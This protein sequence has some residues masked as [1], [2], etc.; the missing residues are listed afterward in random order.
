MADS[1]SRYIH[2]SND[3]NVAER[4]AEETATTGAFLQTLVGTD[5]RGVLVR[6]GVETPADLKE[7]QTL[8]Q[9][10]SN[11]VNR[12][13]YRT[14]FLPSIKREGIR[15]TG[16]T[17]FG[18]DLTLAADRNN[19][20]APS[21]YLNPNAMKTPS[22]GPMTFV[23]SPKLYT[24]MEEMNQVT[25]LGASDRKMPATTSPSSVMLPEE[26]YDKSSR[27]D[28]QRYQSTMN[29]PEPN[30][31]ASLKPPSRRR[32]A[33]H[34]V[35][36]D[37]ESAG[38]L[39]S[40]H[41][42]IIAIGMQVPDKFTKR[43][44]PPTK[45]VQPLVAVPEH[46]AN[47]QLL[48][49][50][51]AQ[52][53]AEQEH[54]LKTNQKTSPA[55][56]HVNGQRRPSVL[57]KA[58][59]TPAPQALSTNAD[60]GMSSI[61]REKQDQ[62]RQGSGFDMNDRR[63]TRV[64]RRDKTN[65]KDSKRQ[66][67]RTCSS[68]GESIAQRLA[69]VRTTSLDSAESDDSA[70]TFATSGGNH[71]VRASF[72]SREEAEML[73]QQ[74][75]GPSL[76]APITTVGAVFPGAF[77][78]VKQEHTAK[79]N[80]TGPSLAPALSAPTPSFAATTPFR[81]DAAPSVMFAVAEEEVEEEEEIEAQ[82][83]IPVTYP[84]AFAVEGMD[85]RHSRPGYDSE[86]TSGL[87]SFGRQ[88]E[89]L[90]TEA[91]LQESL[92]AIDDIALEA[93]LMHEEVVV[94][95]AI[96]IPQDQDDLLAESK[97]VLKRLRRLQMVAVCLCIAAIALISTSIASG[98]SS[99]GGGPDD[100]V[101]SVQGWLQVG[102][103]LW[104]ATTDSG[105]PPTA[106]FGASVA[107][108]SNGRL[109]AVTAPGIDNDESIPAITNVGELHILQQVLDLE[110][111]NPEWINVGKLPGPGS[112]LEEKASL[113][114][115]SDGSI[116][117]VGYSTVLKGGIVQVFEKDKSTGRFP[118]NPSQTFDGVVDTLHGR[119]VDLSSDGTILAIG[120][121]DHDTSNGSNSGMVHI[122]LKV[123][124]KWQQLGDAIEG[125]VQDERFGWSLALSADGLR[126]AVGSSTGLVR[127]LDWQGTSWQERLVGAVDESA[128]RRPAESIALS[129][130]GFVLAVGSVGSVGERDRVRI[131]R[132]AGD[133]VKW[134]ED[135]STKLL[136]GELSGNFGT[137]VSLSS[138][139]SMLA[140]G[141]PQHSQG[142]GMIKVLSYNARSDT[143]VQ[144][145]TN[146]GGSPG[147]TFGSSVS[148]SADGS[149]VVGGGP[150]A[151]FNEA[152]S[153]AG[154]AR[155]YDRARET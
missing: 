82:T 70:Y 49:A 61:Q 2:E 10:P 99:G 90:G 87:S 85:S 89:E 126:I 69:P 4:R 44:E 114:M 52:N 131:F 12:T 86:E 119:A 105:D 152:V 27:N 34:V 67:N 97:V 98:L 106:N 28:S 55:S 94:H 77:L 139:G 35:D 88:H 60:D 154:L 7:P 63:M 54:N 33:R 153:E 124:M 68:S 145:G 135:D 142:S 38:S 65:E 37:D 47:Q 3:A 24:G 64:A 150:S 137:S 20:G 129:A 108:S 115:S 45:K 96:W 123:E 79:Q 6:G 112:S 36:S 81:V 143:W 53:F 73:K 101:P 26:S 14:A 8:R 42:G 95:G 62:A 138:D 100:G 16:I 92:Q 93:E 130:D 80:D 127:V 39:E 19:T 113:A 118:N 110:G 147:S 40:L 109:L 66:A 48:S 132:D 56:A 5:H 91:A 32:F 128:F 104:G 51:V 59:P 22:F 57:R 107:V 17:A 78:V 15:E 148:L 149:R 29:Q 75:S 116:L 84:G 25:Y 50:V 30:D 83:G 102:L 111:D 41:G 103:D 133:V 18:E 141:A 13:H 74:D 120:V 31:E 122:H 23:E 136:G 58:P 21:M 134:L 117:A 1:T 121:P 76:A 9:G 72:R 46:E 155:V 144:E 140:V 151:L 43:V 146:I 71:K 11:P 125:K